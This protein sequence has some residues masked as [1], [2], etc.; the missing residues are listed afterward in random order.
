[1]PEPATQTVM[2]DL[3]R[4]LTEDEKQFIESKGMP[5]ATYS[6]DDLTREIYRVAVIVSRPPS[7]KDMRDHGDIPVQTFQFRFGSW[8]EALEA[9]G[10]ET[11]EGHGAAAPSE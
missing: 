9:A 7:T 10:M 5:N 1:M 2:N 3:G 11:R 8:N 6:E 4:D